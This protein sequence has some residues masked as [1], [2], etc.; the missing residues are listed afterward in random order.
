MMTTESLEIYFKG[1]EIKIFQLLRPNFSITA[2][3]TEILTKI[4][5][6]IKKAV[7]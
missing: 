5:G 7:V 3:T 4:L 2:N 1:T 6:K